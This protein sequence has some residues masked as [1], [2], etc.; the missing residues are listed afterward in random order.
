MK[1]S[2]IM[3]N[4]LIGSPYQIYRIKNKIFIQIKRSKYK[5]KIAKLNKN[6][7]YLVGVIMG[8]GN[9][10]IISRK[11]VSKYPR[12]RIR[13]YNSSIPLLKMLQML[14][15]DSFN[16]SGIITKKK[17]KNCYILEI[18]SKIICS[19]FINFIGLKAEKK[20]N[21]KIPIHVKKKEFFKY[22][23][24]GLMDTDGFYTC[25]TFG[26]MMAGSNEDF[27]KNIKLLSKSLHGLFFLNP[28]KSKL[29]FNEKV[30][31]RVQMN[32][33]RK[34]VIDFYRIIPLKNNKWVEADSNRRY[35]PC[36]GSIITTRS[37]TH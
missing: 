10:T 27:L 9:I 18:N 17:D 20:I 4:N 3:D 1:V 21:L 11:D 30:F 29:I 31:E 7:A 15:K 32:L 24:A 14:F 23:L 13:I 2:K 33:S 19:Y 26:I 37:P 6:I 35:L 36:K 5:I 8:D 25:K 22:F 34:S 16:Y 28:M 12:T